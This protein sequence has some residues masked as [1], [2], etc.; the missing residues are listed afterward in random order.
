LSFV[1]V[2][3]FLLRLHEAHIAAIQ[4]LSRLTFL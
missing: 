4:S 2:F 3:I 1:L